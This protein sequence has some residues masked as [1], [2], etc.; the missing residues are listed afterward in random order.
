MFISKLRSKVKPKNIDSFDDL[1]NNQKKIIIKGEH[2]VHDFF[3]DSGSVAVKR[4]KGEHILLGSNFF[5][6]EL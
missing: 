4:V 1:Y 2:F 3:Q 5:V 6:T